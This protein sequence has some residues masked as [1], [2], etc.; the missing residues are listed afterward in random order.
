MKRA[1]RNF[2]I[3]AAGLALIAACGGGGSDSDGGLTGGAPPSEPATITTENAPL[4]A[5]TVAEVA[6][7]QGIFSSIFTTDLPIGSIGADAA[8]SP[9]MKPVFS[10]A[11]KTASPSQLY[12]TS[13]GRENC[14]VSGTVDIQVT[15]SD[16]TGPSGS[17]APMAT[18]SCITLTAFSVHRAPWFGCGHGRRKTGLDSATRRGTG[19]STVARS[20]IATYVT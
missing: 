12:A 10:A 3:A 16:P 14:A 1:L 19:C 6:M 15:I 7:G 13:A 8:V 4:I 9:V 2:F 11:M 17:K 5:G 20:L 18:L